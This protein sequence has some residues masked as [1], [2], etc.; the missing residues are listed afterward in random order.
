MKEED[1]VAVKT[2]RDFTASLE[3]YYIIWWVANSHSFPLETVLLLILI[4][5]MYILCLRSG[6]RGLY[7]SYSTL[8]A[9]R[10]Y[11]SILKQ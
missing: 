7:S 11:I 8:S 1:S 10:G 3:S 6:N 4:L 2:R 9:W 5:K